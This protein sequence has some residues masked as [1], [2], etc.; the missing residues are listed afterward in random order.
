[1]PLGIAGAAPRPS[2]NRSARRSP[3]MAVSCYVVGAVLRLAFAKP[4]T[5][6]APLRFG[7]AETAQGDGPGPKKCQ[8]DLHEGG[9]ERGRREGESEEGNGRGEGQ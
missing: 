3:I 9:S 7:L 6:L 2:A 8:P 5:R 4:T 1:M